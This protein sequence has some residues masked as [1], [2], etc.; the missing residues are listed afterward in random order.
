MR[1]L[2]TVL[3]AFFPIAAFADDYSIGDLVVAQPTAFATPPSAMAGAGYLSITNN[4]A[5][6]DSLIAVEADFPRV[7]I[8]DTKVTDGV[9]TMMHVDSIVIAP[10]ETV[11]LAPGG[12]HVMFMGLDGD[13]LEVGETVNATLIFEQAGRLDVTF[14]VEERP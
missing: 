7:M 1:I 4:G 3:V 10:G 9:A 6:A 5:E 11:T 8:H 13:P 14:A 2:T 12:M